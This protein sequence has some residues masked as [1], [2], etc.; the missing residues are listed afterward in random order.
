VSGPQYACLNQK[1]G[2]REAESASARYLA[3]CNRRSS[4][5]ITV[6][7]RDSAS[8]ETYGEEGEDSEAADGSFRTCVFAD[9]T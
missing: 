3:S 2:G 7:L 5:Y 4:V 1:G 8:G 9:A 6:V